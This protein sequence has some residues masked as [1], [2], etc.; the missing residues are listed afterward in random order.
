MVAARFEDLVVWQRARRLS[1]EVY[2]ATRS[3]SFARDRGLREQIQRA[4]V[5]VMS[6]IAEGFERR[7]RREFARSLSIALGS[8]GE[9]R[10]QL[11]LAHDLEYLQAETLKHL[12][13]L[14]EEVRAMLIALRRSQGT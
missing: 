13:V 14:S 11:Y 5:S 9:V 7:S 3:G 12:L 4:A 2:R 10:S 8:A 1:S 6:N